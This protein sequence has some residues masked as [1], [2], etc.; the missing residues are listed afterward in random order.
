MR[1]RHFFFAD[2]VLLVLAVYASYVLRLDGFYLGRYWPD[3]FL[4]IFLAVVMT[5]LVFRKIGIY[6]CYWRYASVDELLLLIYGV[7]GTAVIFSI[8]RIII[9]VILPF[10]PDTIRSIPLIYIPLAIGATAGPRLLIRAIS[11]HS[12]KEKGTAIPIST[13]IMGAGS[14]GIMMVRELK[15]N[16]HLG[17]EVVGFLDDNPD[18]TGMLIHGIRV[19]GNRND[20]P[21]LVRQIPVQRIIIAMPTVPG[22]TIGDILAICRQVGVE[23]KIIPGVFELLGGTV[24]VNQLRNVEIEDLLRREPIHTDTAAVG[25]LIR[26][27]RILVTGGGGSIG[28]E[29]CRQIMRYHPATLIVVGHGENSVFE[30]QT[31]LRQKFFTN[32]G[33]PNIYAGYNGNLDAQS[34]PPKEMITTDEGIPPTELTTVIADIRFPERLQSIFET[35]RPEIVFHAAAHKHVPLM[36][37]NPAEAISNNVMGTRN[38]LTA[39]LDTGVERFV[40]ISSDKAVNPTSFMGASKR[41]AELLVHQ[42]AQTSGRPYTAVRFGN[43]LG[44]RGSV[45]LTFKQ[46]IA[47]GGPVTVTDPEMRRY[48]MT[49]PEAV[50]LVLQAAVLGQAGAVFVLDMGEP[51]K[52]MDLA[53][54]MIKLS[55]LELGRDIDIV[56]TGPRPGEKLFEELFIPGE[57]YQ[58][59]RHEKIYIAQNVTNQVLPNLDETISM[60]ISAAQKDDRAAILA[61]LQCL[62]PEFQPTVNYPI[63]KFAKSPQSVSISG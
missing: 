28:S 32:N 29:L 12:H 26:G 9:T 53:R 22:K 13:L 58:R 45:V 6:S 57:I 54:D 31:G 52:I 36:E 41:A 44:S 10:F 3:F 50:Q 19:L 17:I 16:P 1:N 14:A 61:A 63:E 2:L 60:L 21:H 15:Q 48:F 7:A 43:V 5:P 47:T 62:I 34:V 23:T 42:A 56:I 55:G 35:Y 49:I 25:E 59:T 18:K 4:F 8:A 39:A 30:I 33:I 51:I 40:L 46:Q 37:L 20:I 11:H 27:K 38:L 24:T